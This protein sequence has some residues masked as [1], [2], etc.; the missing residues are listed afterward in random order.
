MSDIHS[1][2]IFLRSPIKLY[3][4]SLPQEYDFLDENPNR[5]QVEVHHPGYSPTDSL[6]FTFYAWDHPNGGLHFN[7][8][9]CACLVIADNQEGYLSSSSGGAPIDAQPD[10]LLR[11]GK[12]Y[13]HV[14]HTG[15][16]FERFI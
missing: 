14:P 13:Y 11:A 12:Y 7:F 8:V 16:C 5:F 2:K 1:D 4:P 15:K 3:S 10:S 9:Y 6:L